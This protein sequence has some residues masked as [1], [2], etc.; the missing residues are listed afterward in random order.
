MDK[1]TIFEAG[2][3]IML[4]QNEYI[5]EG[6]EGIVYRLGNKVFKIYS[7]ETKV[8]PQGKFNELSGLDMHNIVRPLD[9]IYDSRGQAIG[10]SMQAVDQADALT[11]W[12]TNDYR[13]AEGI[14]NELVYKLIQSIREVTSY[15]HDK[16][17]L[18]VDGNEMNYL[19]N[20]K[21][22]PYFIDVDS[23][24]TPSFA[25][26]AIMPSIRDWTVGPKN[27]STGSDWFSFAV[28]AC[29]LLVGIHPFK[30]RHKD[31]KRGD[32]EGRVKANVSIFGGDVKMPSAVRD[33]SL[34]PDNYRDWFEA[35]LQNGERIAP[36]ELIG[37]I[38]GLK[39]YIGKQIIAQKLT[40]QEISSLEETVTAVFSAFNKLF[41]KT[42]STL[43][44][45]NETWRFKDSTTQVIVTAQSQIPIMA[46][47]EHGRFVYLNTQNSKIVDDGLKV[48][49]LM[50]YENR[51]Y[52]IEGKN[53]YEFGVIEMGKAIKITS[54]ARTIMPNASTL[55]E[56]LLHQDL[57]G[58]AFWMLPYKANNVAFINISELNGKPILNAR[59]MRGI[60]VVITIE[61]GE[62]IRR[63]IKFSED[64]KSYLIMD[65]STVDQIEI[66]FTVLDRGVCILIPEDGEMWVFDT[67]LDK[68]SVNKVKDKGVLLEMKL[69]NANEKVYGI[70]GKQVFSISL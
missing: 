32:F 40:L 41:I 59:Y 55:F 42:D 65:T 27:F 63:V 15:I 49:K 66:N 45:D 19:V 68:D 3:Q 17:C 24:Q 14:T 9:F 61:S 51:L 60:A 10:Y 30:G 4:T 23:Y 53:F 12:F 28:I 52:G 48:N 16:S 6:G 18:I 11:R 2:K 57:M 31:F 29:Q 54:K 1:R 22:T 33:F 5:A 62:Y 34:I 26:T 46:K 39:S 38:S 64:H 43:I 58:K 67:R 25:A 56:G 44:Q 36:P 70:I 47:V 37:A 69:Q 21:G 20:A 13:Q 8:L 35:V 50:T 7:D